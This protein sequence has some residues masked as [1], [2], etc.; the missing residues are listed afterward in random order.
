MR[1]IRRFV[2]PAVLLLLHAGPKHGYGIAAGLGELGLAG[3]AVDPSVI[4]RA[5]YALEEL[6]MVS[7]TTD[8]VETAGP[9]RRV[10][11]LTDQ[12]D[13]YLR[14]WVLD[15]RETERM[16]QRFLAVYDQAHSGDAPG[17]EGHE[18]A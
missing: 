3:Y 4:Y 13:A 15:L 11:R 8:A 7:S 6:G 12:G 10:Y 14:E 1:G 18:Q 9:P 5:L 2:E 16:L 17:P